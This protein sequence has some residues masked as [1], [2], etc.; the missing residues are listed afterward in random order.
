MKKSLVLLFTFLGLF[1]IMIVKYMSFQKY[2]LILLFFVLSVKSII[3]KYILDDY[4]FDIP[5]KLINLY[6]IS[7]YRSCSNTDKTPINFSEQLM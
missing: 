4:K 6:N 3:E 5:K 7:G 1:S 2:H